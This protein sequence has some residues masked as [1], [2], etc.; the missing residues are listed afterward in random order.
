IINKKLSSTGGELIEKTRELIEK[1]NYIEMLQEY[2]D[3]YRDLITIGLVYG[4]D[5]H[6]MRNKLGYA[7][8]RA[9]NVLEGRYGEDI[10]KI[11]NEVRN[12]S[13]NITS[14]IKHINEMQEDIQPSLD[15]E[16]VNVNGLLDQSLLKSRIN[17]P[18]YVNVERNYHLSSNYKINVPKY[19]VQQVFLIL[20]HNAINAMYGSDSGVLTL[21]TV[22]DDSAEMPRVK[23]TI[24]DTG[25]GI[26][27]HV[28][29]NLFKLKSTSGD[30]RRGVGMGL[31]WA[32][33]FMT[34]IGGHLSFSTSEKGTKMY[35]LIPK[36]NRYLKLG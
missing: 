2:Y 34:T 13:E 6:M 15:Y 28:Q 14:Y 9:A 24:T 20:I 31:P 30:N 27:V 8:I 36:N 33:A 3:S 5:V 7:R 16:E 25:T 19:Q 26:P 18:S 32:R 4:D 17:I 10:E 12:I 11:K 35:I 22:L 21:S 23:V 1:T 29:D